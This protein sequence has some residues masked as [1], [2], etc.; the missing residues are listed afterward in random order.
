MCNLINLLNIVEDTDF[1]FYALIIILIILALILFYLVFVQ[2]KTKVKNDNV[3][4]VQET[5]KNDETITEEKEKPELVQVVDAEIPDK[6]EYTQALW[7]N[8]FL[9]LQ[10]IT[11][12][13]EQAPKQKKV[14]MT[15]YEAEQEEKAIIS[16]DELISKKDEIIKYDESTNNT[17]DD[18]MIRK[19][20]LD[21]TAKSEIVDDN[22]EIGNY[23]HEEAFLDALKQL[24]K[25]IN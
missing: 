3:V 21:K 9:E 25:V 10:D 16:Y 4:N 6:L 15:A 13:L 12:E 5:R 19:V 8:D 22:E 18:I 24:Q 14:N 7:Q 1:V 11:R 2:N 20:D 17:L 23:V